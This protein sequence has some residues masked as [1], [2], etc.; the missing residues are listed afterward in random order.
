MSTNIENQGSPCDCND[1]EH[2]DHKD[3]NRHK[4]VADECM[5]DD[6]SKHKIHSR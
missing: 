3:R 6:G 5:H 4:H 1:D 2:H